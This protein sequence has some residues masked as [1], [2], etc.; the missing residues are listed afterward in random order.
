VPELRRDRPQRLMLN[1]RRNRRA[2]GDLRR[3][4]SEALLHG[5]DRVLSQVR[6]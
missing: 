3:D 6:L 2:R 1:R 5:A 4:P